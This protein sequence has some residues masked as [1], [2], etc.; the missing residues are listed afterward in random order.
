M[1][2]GQPS[3]LPGAR[4]LVHVLFGEGMGL[5]VADARRILPVER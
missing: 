2:R 1:R 3:I 5:P 4:G